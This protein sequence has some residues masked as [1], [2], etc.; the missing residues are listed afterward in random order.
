MAIRRGKTQ[1]GHVEEQPISENV[2]KYAVFG[3]GRPVKRGVPNLSKQI[4]QRMANSMTQRLELRATTRLAYLSENSLFEQR[5]REREREREKV[6][7]RNQ[8]TRKRPIYEYS[9]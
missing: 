9:R 5:E 2:R 4:L 1:C 8:S 7:D 3:L 6:P